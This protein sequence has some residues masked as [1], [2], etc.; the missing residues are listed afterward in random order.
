M[1]SAELRRVEAALA[2]RIP[3]RIVP[4]LDRIRDLLDV[5]GSPQRAYPSVHVAGTNGKTSTTR[6]IDALLRAFGIRT[7]RY[8]SPHLETVTERI[9]VDGEPVSDEAF[10]AAYDD[11]APYAE[12]VDGKHTDRVTYYE[13]LTAMAFAHFADVPVDA[14]VI[15]VGLGGRWDATNVLNAPVAVVTPIGLDHTQYLGES[16]A[17]IAVEKAAI[18]APGATLVAAGQAPDAAA[19]LLARAVEVGAGMLREGV[20]FGVLHRRL[21]VG[22]QQLTLRGL[23]GDYEDI[24][25]PLFGAHQASNAACALAAVEA[26]LGGGRGLLDVDAVREGFAAADSPGRLEVVR[27]SPTVVLDAA[28]NPAGAAAT[29]TAL[30]ES[31]AF[32]R[33]TAVVGVLNDKDARGILEALEPVAAEVV[34]TTPDSSRAL[35]AAELAEVAEEVFGA[36]RVRVEPA[37]PDALDAGI[38]AAEADASYGGA[39]VLVT[40]SVVTVGTARSLLRR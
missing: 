6:M 31:F 32:T 13:L 3:T 38:T 25:L 5:L 15:E 9:V 14:A 39:G 26:F 36:D 20:E 35:P 1:G 29:V 19:V 37:L 8:T 22:G 28:H 30:S 12:L 16:L 2:A 10:A 18:V 23:G 21:A 11:V 33:L 4:D 27:T 7:G 24:L 40:G 17:A 34:V